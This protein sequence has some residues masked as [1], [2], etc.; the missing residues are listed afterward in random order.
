MSANRQ[1]GAA[2][3]ICLMLLSV[4]TLLATSTLGT[5]AIA[6]ALAGND[7]YQTRAFEAAEAGIERAIAVI[8]AGGATPGTI[9]S[10]I[11]GTLA[12][13][14]SYEAVIRMRGTTA[15]PPGYLDTF[16]AEHFEIE[17]TGTSLRDA[18]TTLVQGLFRVQ[19]PAVGGETTP[20]A[21]PACLPGIELRLNLC[22]ETGWTVRTYWRTAAAAGT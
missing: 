13:G 10:T 3:V 22:V 4:L 21:P 9:A 16:T 5:A 11:A 20:G 14:D 12:S 2:L 19:P 8:A 15:P 1:T 7:Q 6:L 17:S 18:Q